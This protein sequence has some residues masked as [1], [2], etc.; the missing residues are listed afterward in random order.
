MEALPSAKFAGSQNLQEKISQLSHHLYV[1]H[2]H[3]NTGILREGNRA[4]PHRPKWGY[5]SHHTRRTGHHLY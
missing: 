2:G 1:H 5:A 3:V 4:L